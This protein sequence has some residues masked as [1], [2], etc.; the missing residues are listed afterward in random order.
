MSVDLLKKEAVVRL[1]EAVDLLKSVDARV[2]ISTDPMVI[3]MCT[4]PRFNLPMPMNAT[5]WG[6]DEPT[7]YNSC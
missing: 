4:D 2:V 1:E 6:L 5:H 3:Q 7:E